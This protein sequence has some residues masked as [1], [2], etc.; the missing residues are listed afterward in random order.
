METI[1]KIR[2]HAETNEA[3]NL[4]YNNIELGTKQLEVDI[5]LRLIYQK[6]HFPIF[7]HILLVTIF[8]SYI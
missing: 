2:S 3:N 1:A 6:E 8:L 4:V 5:F 7:T